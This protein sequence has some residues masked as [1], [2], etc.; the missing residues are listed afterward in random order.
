MSGFQ[1][2][3]PLSTIAGTSAYS[4]LEWFGYS[5]QSQGV[6]WERKA[7]FKVKVKWLLSEPAPAVITRGFGRSV[8]TFIYAAS[9]IGWTEPMTSTGNPSRWSSDASGGFGRADVVS[10]LLGLTGNANSET[11]GTSDEDSMNGRGHST[12]AH[13]PWMD[14]FD[15]IDCKPEGVPKKVFDA[16]KGKWYN[17]QYF[18]HKSTEALGS[19]ESSSASN[20]FLPWSTFE[21]FGFSGISLEFGIISSDTTTWSYAP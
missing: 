14:S 12:S 5:F 21:C 19:A 9:A 2:P 20:I 11:Y 18:V 8:R 10:S 13:S 7:D 16:E 17:E 3:D 1:A 4:S 15:Y 6:E